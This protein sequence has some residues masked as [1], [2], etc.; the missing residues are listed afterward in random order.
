MR[1]NLDRYSVTRSARRLANRNQD[2]D[3]V[4][5][6]ASPDLE[7][8]RLY[9]RHK[10]RFDSSEPASSDSFESYANSFYS[11]YGAR[12]AIS[13]R[14][15]GR[16]LSRIH[17]DITERAASAIYCYYDDSKPERSLGTFSINLAIDLAKRR[18]CRHL[19][20]GYF[21]RENHS[22]RYKIRFHPIEV[23]DHGRWISVANSS[24]DIDPV[25]TRSEGPW[26]RHR[27]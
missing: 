4:V 19:Y 24:V 11:P 16:L 5:H 13:L 14:G 22:M 26:S 6:R 8:Y 15:Q 1:V 18:G 10:T 20:L 25:L 23:L 21:I 9:K 7:S 2:L 12:W 27:P 17:L 3:A